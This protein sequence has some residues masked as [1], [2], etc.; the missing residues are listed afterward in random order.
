[1][2]L[3][4]ITNFFT[5]GVYGWTETIYT[6]AASLETAMINAQIIF[7]KRRDLN[8]FE[9][10]L[11]AIRVSNDLTRGDSIFFDVPASQQSNK[12]GG[13]LRINQAPDGIEIRLTSSSTIRRILILRGIEDEVQVGGAFAPNAN[14]NVN[15]PLWR[16]AITSGIFCLKHLKN[17]GTGSVLTTMVNDYTSGRINITTLNPITTIDTGALVYIG[18]GRGAPGLRGYWR[19]VKT[20][21]NSFYITSRANVLNITPTWYVRLADYDLTA[22]VTATVGR[23]GTR[24]TGR[25]SFGPRGRRPARPRI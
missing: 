17:P 15:F 11:T 7:P 10:L 20:G 9:V 18:G 3:Y 22:I 19:V 12:D 21:P 23:L 25:P 8:S 1:M 6:N 2:P 24:R 13:P 16:A 5:V 4:R 14:W